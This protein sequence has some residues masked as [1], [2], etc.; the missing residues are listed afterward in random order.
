MAVYTFV[1]E[2]NEDQ[3]MGDTLPTI[4][5]NYVNLNNAILAVSASNILLKNQHNTLIQTLTGI[6]AVGTTYNSLSTTFLTLST[7]IIP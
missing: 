1:T 2:I 3:C 6:G 7:L 5:S 4:N